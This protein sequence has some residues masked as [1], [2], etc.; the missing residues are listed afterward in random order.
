MVVETRLHSV[1]VLIAETAA[2]PQCP[3]RNGITL[4]PWARIDK[5]RSFFRHG[6]AQR[7]LPIAVSVFR[8]KR[9]V[10]VNLLL[11]ILLR[12]EE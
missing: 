11:V 3:K 7:R 2:I 4:A 1:E 6:V 12:I 10:C 9:S 5:I 8:A